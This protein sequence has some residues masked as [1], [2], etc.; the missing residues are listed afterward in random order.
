MYA[1]VEIAGSQVK[2][3]KSQKVYVPYLRSKVGSTL[4]FDKVLLR[5]DENKTTV[6]SPYID[7][8]TVEAKALAHPKDGKATRTDATA[9]R[10]GW[11]SSGL[12]VRLCGRE[13]S[14]YGSGAPKFIPAPMSGSAAM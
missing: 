11:A 7:G 12:A 3:E 13:T 8:A 14:S 1:I 6:G 10:N 4:K 5:S 9:M 2:V